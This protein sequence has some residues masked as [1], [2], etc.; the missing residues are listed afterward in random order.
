[1]LLIYAYN[2]A[3]LVVDVLLVLVLV[4]LFAQICA[5]GPT[6]TYDRA[7]AE[8][9]YDFDMSR[10]RFCRRNVV[11]LPPAK[12]MRALGP[13]HQ[14][15]TDVAMRALGPFPRPATDAACAGIDASRSFGDGRSVGSCWDF[16]FRLGYVLGFRVGR[17]CPFP[18]Y[19]LKPPKY[20]S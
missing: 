9:A 13:L 6:V 7:A 10:L 5:A 1:M 2:I 15:A 18:G 3:Y 14:P 19:R 11:A 17:S 16:G 8:S 4:L 12:C 20:L